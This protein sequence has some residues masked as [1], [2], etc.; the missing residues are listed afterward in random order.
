MVIA[1]GRMLV[2][3]KVI[4]TTKDLRVGLFESTDNF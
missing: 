3:N 4:Y 2:D 1:D